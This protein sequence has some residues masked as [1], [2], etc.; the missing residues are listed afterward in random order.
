MGKILIST[1]DEIGPEQVQKIEQAAKRVFGKEYE[2][3][4][5][6]WN[7]ENEN[8]LSALLEKLIEENCET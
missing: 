3:I 5:W 8:E 6:Y 2:T 7:G 1:D 4:S